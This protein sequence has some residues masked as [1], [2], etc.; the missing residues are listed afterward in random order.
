MSTHIF[1]LI[2]PPLHSPT[3][4]PVELCPSGSKRIDE[5][6]DVARGEVGILE[7]KTSLVDP[8]QLLHELVDYVAPAASSHGQSLVLEA[9]PSF[10]AVVA[11][12]GR[13]RQVVLN[14]LDNAIKFTPQGGEITLRA[15]VE[16]SNLIVEVQDTGPGVAQ[17]EQK[18]LFT[19]YYHHSG[20]G[21]SGL[22]LG[23][24]LCKT[25]VE[26]HGGQIWVKSRK[27][28]GSTFAFSVPLTPA[29]WRDGDG[30]RR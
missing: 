13:L 27:G 26:L 23:L 2:S 19:P 21:P 12:R 7:L 30:E 29:W 24:A 25:L 6:L 11:D 10:P 14:L 5:L 1:Y 8:L 18:R 16:D 9:L 28:K 20:D 17:K 15:K 22:G 4:K 3:G